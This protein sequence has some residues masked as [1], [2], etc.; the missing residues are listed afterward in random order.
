MATKRGT[1]GAPPSKIVKG[2]FE[3]A[4]PWVGG[5]VRVKWPATGLHALIAIGVACLTF[6]VVVPTSLYII[7]VGAVPEN[8]SRFGQL[9]RSN[10]YGTKPDQYRPPEKVPINTNRG[11]EYVDLC[12]PCPRCE[13]PMST[14]IETFGGPAPLLPPEPSHDAGPDQ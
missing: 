10:T 3:I 11:V 2:R 13:L 14:S 1:S 9:V 4:F 8:I 6:L 5:S 7:F 12:P